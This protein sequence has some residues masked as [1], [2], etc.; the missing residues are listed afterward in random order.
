MGTIRKEKLDAC[1]DIYQLSSVKPKNQWQESVHKITALCN[2]NLLSPFLLQ[3]DSW[4]PE[5]S[6]NLVKITQ[7]A[8]NYCCC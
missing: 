6:S 2:W 4:G 7:L 5:R 1:G 8:I 3:G